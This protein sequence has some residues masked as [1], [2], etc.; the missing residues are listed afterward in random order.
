[1]DSFKLINDGHENILNYV[2]IKIDLFIYNLGYLPGSNKQIKTTAK[3]T[4]KSLKVSIE[5]LLNIGGI[6]FM[7][8][9][10]GHDGG[11]EEYEIVVNY[12]KKLNQKKYSIIRHEYI[13]QKNNPPILIIIERLY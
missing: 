12:L 7:V 13:N 8:F 5:N 10:T 3:S 2:N 1:K 6:I 11:Y 9:Y 4:L